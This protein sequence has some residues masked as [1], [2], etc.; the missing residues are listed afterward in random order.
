[1]ST[2]IA[3]AYANAGNSGQEFI[4]NLALF[5]ANFLSNHVHAIEGETHQSGLLNAHFYLIKVSQVEDME[6]FKICLGYWSKLTSE[7]F[8][9]SQKSTMST[10]PSLAAAGASSGGKKPTT[11]KK[12]RKDIYV[13]VL[14]NLRLVVIERMVKPEEVC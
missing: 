1:M 13:N 2:N 6:I 7:L 12:S 9:I 10:S 11:A 14:S 4:F 5:L 3:Q 8:E